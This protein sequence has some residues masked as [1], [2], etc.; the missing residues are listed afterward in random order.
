MATAGKTAMAMARRG[1]ST[2]T[3]ARA[4]PING[5]KTPRWICNVPEPGSSALAG[6]PWHALRPILDSG[7]QFVA[8]MGAAR[9]QGAVDSDPGSKLKLKCV[10][11]LL[12]LERRLPAGEPGR[13]RAD[14][15]GRKAPDIPFAA[16]AGRLPV[17]CA[18]HR[19]RPRSR[20]HQPGSS[21][22]ARPAF[23]SIK[24]RSWV[25]VACG[26]RSRAAR[27]RAP[28]HRL[29]QPVVFHEFGIHPTPR[30]RC[31]RC[32][33]AG[34]PRHYR[35][36]RRCR[37]PVRAA[38]RRP[39]CGRKVASHQRSW[40]KHSCQCLADPSH[41]MPPITMPPG[42]TSSEPCRRGQADRLPVGRVAVTGAQQ[43]PQGRV[44]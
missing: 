11:S 22:P 27:S 15:T 26:G 28:A 17:A 24:P 43:P 37:R 13:Q 20:R 36:P 3:A 23:C 5:R 8:G 29:V 6:I 14:L 18:R 21:E 38:A 40:R 41:R 10:V 42:I 1:C 9:G 39:G 16:V 19:R 35:T 34:W 2:T 12:Q 25:V 4:C 7:R 30:A 44:A 32:R 31:P 33:R